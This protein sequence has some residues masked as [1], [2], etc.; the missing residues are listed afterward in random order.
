MPQGIARVRGMHIS[1]ARPHQPVGPIVLRISSDRNCQTLSYSLVYQPSL[2]PGYQHRIPD[3]VSLGRENH[4]LLHYWFQEFLCC[5]QMDIFVSR[6]R[7]A[8]L[9]GILLALL[10]ILQ[11]VS[12]V[13]AGSRFVVSIPED[14]A[15]LTHALLRLHLRPATSKSLTGFQISLCLFA[16]T[17]V[18]IFI[19]MQMEIIIFSSAPSFPSFIH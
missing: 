12:L 7:P 2:Q 14:V 15:S 4:L 19:T 17:P 1:G 5:I 3:I 18:D 8:E 11:C 6:S 16:C 13:V 10:K 9:S